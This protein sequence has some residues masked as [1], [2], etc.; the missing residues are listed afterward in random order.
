MKDL[1]MGQKYDV[2]IPTFLKEGRSVYDF[3]PGF[4]GTPVNINKY[5]DE[6]LQDYIT[7]L[8][9]VSVGFEERIWING[10]PGG[11]GGSGGS[12]GSSKTVTVILTIVFTL[13]FLGAVYIGVAYIYPKLRG[14]PHP[15]RFD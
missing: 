3:A 14:T 4:F 12:K 8:G 15:H 7:G 1:D 5:D 10:I 11:G 13:I 2:V 9:V 6:C